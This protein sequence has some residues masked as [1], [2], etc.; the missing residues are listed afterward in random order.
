MWNEWGYSA[1]MTRPHHFWLNTVS[2]TRQTYNSWRDMRYRCFNPKNVA[3]P[4]YGG[5][6]ISVC[7]RWRDN[8]DAFV[9]DMGLRPHGMT[10]DRIDNDKDY[11]PENCRWATM[12]EQS[13]NRSMNVRHGTVF[14]ETDIAQKAKINLRTLRSRLDTGMPLQ[15]ALIKPV[16]K[17][18]KESPHGS[19]KRYDRHGCRCDLCKSAN[20][21]YARQQRARRKAR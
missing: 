14:I 1:L 20:A 13:R 10:I 6:G 8:Y 12:H 18:S 21:E 5:R 15:E 16:R 11:T 9:E 4:Y 2:A 3:Y 7:E 17:L 19:R